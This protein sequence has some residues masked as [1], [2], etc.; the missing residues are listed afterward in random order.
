M[1]RAN[2]FG[3][4]C[5]RGGGQCDLGFHRAVCEA[6]GKQAITSAFSTTFVASLRETMLARG[7][8]QALKTRCES[9]DAIQGTLM[10]LPPPSLQGDAERARQRMRDT[11][12]LFER[13]FYCAAQDR[14]PRVGGMTLPAA[15]HAALAQACN[16]STIALSGGI[17]TAYPSRRA[18]PKCGGAGGGY[19]LSCGLGGRCPLR[20]NRTG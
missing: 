4:P 2:R 3:R 11:C 16:P 6:T 7:G 9:R 15:L 8:L 13:A 18:G 1:T 5:G 20:A 17:G 14:P 10:T 19:A 12:K